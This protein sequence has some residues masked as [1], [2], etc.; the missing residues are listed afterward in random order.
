MN[1]SLILLVLGT[2][3]LVL[4]PPQAAAQCRYECVALYDVEGRPVGYQCVAFTD[5]DITCRPTSTWCLNSSCSGAWVTDTNGTVLAEADICRD[6]VTLRP[7]SRPG[8]V[9]ALKPYRLRA[10]K[11]EFATE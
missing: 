5:T 1:R 11:R 10:P 3:L 2:C 9:I 8:K 4:K 7:I 6:K